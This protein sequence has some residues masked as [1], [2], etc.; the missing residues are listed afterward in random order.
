MTM[1]RS[2]IASLMIAV[3]TFV[4]T[5]QMAIAGDYVWARSA[6]GNGSWGRNYS[7]MSNGY[8]GYYV[9]RNAYGNNYER[10]A[11]YRN[12]NGYIVSSQPAVSTPR[13]CDHPLISAQSNPPKT[14]IVDAPK[15]AENSANTATSARC[16]RALST[17]HRR[18]QAGR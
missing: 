16:T 10:R 1:N 13:P 3:C 6:W 18:K 8:G 9:P 15:A 5:S 11:P 12:P 2:Y 7:G 4:L 14:T 17:I